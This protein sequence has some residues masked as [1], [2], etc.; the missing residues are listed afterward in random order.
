M[1]LAVVLAS[2][3]AASARDPYPLHVE[4]A[5]GAEACDDVTALRLRIE[6]IF[7]TARLRM[8]PAESGPLSVS[9][10]RTTDGRLSARLAT[11]GAKVGQRELSDPGPS[12]EALSEAVGVAIA[13]LFD[14]MLTETPPKPVDAPRDRNIGDRSRAASHEANPKIQAAARADRLRASVEVGAGLGL[15]ADVSLHLGGWLGVRAGPFVLDAGGNVDLSPSRDFAGGSLRTSL[16]YGTLR[17]CWL[18]GRSISV[19]PCAQLGLGLVHGAGQDYAE[20]RTSSLTWTAA[21]AG[22]LGAAP[23]G[24][25]AYLTLAATAWVPTRRLTLSVQN[26]GI[27][28]ESSTVAVSLAAGFGASWF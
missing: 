24:R 21:G 15:V 6:R 1:L 13:V 12:C 20:T 25:H 8:L 23:L 5:S 7:G 10:R 19:G 4:R 14:G 11:A 26:V 16:W 17:G 22:L 18:F 27:A 9:F 2:P 3:R 28:W